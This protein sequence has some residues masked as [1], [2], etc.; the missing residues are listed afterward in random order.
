MNNYRTYDFCDLTPDVPD[1]N[2]RDA[3]QIHPGE[4][5]MRC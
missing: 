5:S 1:P 3:F 2:G 4:T